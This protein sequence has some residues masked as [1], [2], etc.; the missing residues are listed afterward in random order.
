MI[1]FLDIFVLMIV[2]MLL[3]LAEGLYLDP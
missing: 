1:H 3:G 2:P